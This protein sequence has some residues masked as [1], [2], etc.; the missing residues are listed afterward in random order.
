MPLHVPSFVLGMAVMG[1]PLARR[2]PRALIVNAATAGADLFESARR[3][4]AEQMEALE[5]FAAEVQARRDGLQA[6]GGEGAPRA[7]RSRARKR[8]SQP[9]ARSA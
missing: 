7:P 6:T 9:D 2:I 5:D 3:R 4:L 1:L 8:T